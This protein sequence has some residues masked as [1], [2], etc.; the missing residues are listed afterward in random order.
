MSDLKQ[1]F[2]KK[3]THTELK[4]LA[5]QEEVTMT[6]LVDKIC[7]DYVKKIQDKE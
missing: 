1:I 7:K 3:D 4:I 6:E 5:A 2:V